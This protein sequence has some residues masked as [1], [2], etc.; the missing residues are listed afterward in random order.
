MSV[1]T[2]IAC[3]TIYPDHRCSECKHDSCFNFM[4]VTFSCFKS[5]GGV[6]NDGRLF[7]GF[8]AVGLQ[9]NMQ[10]SGKFRTSNKPTSIV[11]TPMVMYRL[12]IISAEPRTSTLLHNYNAEKNSNPWSFFGS[13]P[14]GCQLA[15]DNAIGIG[16]ADS[17]PSTICKNM[18]QY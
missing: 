3:F 8:P 13:C 14:G 15:S 7:T 12:E 2:T 4:E 5:G 9:K 10:S 17:I 6:T 11:S 18:G 1:S 16:G